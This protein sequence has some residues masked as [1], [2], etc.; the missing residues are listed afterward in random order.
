[1][2]KKSDEKLSPPEW[3]RRFD[4]A[5]AIVAR[6]YCDMF[7][8]W[9]NCRYKPCRSTR[10]CSGDEADCLNRGWVTIPYESLYE[11]R[12]RMVAEA[13]TNADGFL[14][15]AHS[16]PPSSACLCLTKNPKTLAKAR[17]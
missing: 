10:R 15:L 12:D 2:S 3:Q 7:E 17:S 16:F 9:R 11:A 14:R 13:P 4:A 1:M 8:F 5:C 6:K